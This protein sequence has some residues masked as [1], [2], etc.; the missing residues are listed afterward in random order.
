MFQFLNRQKYKKRVLGS[1][2]AMLYLYPRGRDNIIKDYPGIRDS[3]K[4]NFGEGTKPQRAALLAS[5]AILANLVETLSADQRALI[6]GQL[7]QMDMRQIRAM[8]RDVMAGKSFPKEIAFG[9]IMIGNA[10]MMARTLV[11]DKEVE[12]SDYDMFASEVFGAL[13][14]G[15]LRSGHANESM[16]CLTRLFLCQSSRKVTK[17][18]CCQNRR[19]RPSYRHSRALR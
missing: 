14:A 16:P 3:I 17:D 10:I 12:Q 9:T 1:L 4:S 2:Y 8:L 15:R 5:A 11:E 13:R 19:D 7:R 18:R 6:Y